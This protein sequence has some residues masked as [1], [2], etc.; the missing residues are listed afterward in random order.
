MELEFLNGIKNYFSTTFKQQI[1]VS[2]DEEGHSV[3]KALSAI[4]PAG[5]MA[6]IHHAEKDDGGA[7][8]YQLAQNATAYHPATQ[9][10]ALL[11]NEDGEKLTS[12]LL[13]DREKVI[14]HSVAK[15]AGI[16][17]ESA[18]AIMYVAIP[19]LLRS[20]DGYAREKNLSGE[21][22]KTF[23]NSQKP[24]LNNLI[25]QG[26]EPVVQDIE[27]E[28]AAF[29]KEVVEAVTTDSVKKNNTAWILPVA[30]AILAALM[31]IYFSRGT[32][33]LK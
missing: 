18:S 30:L 24:H 25:P 6:A 12:D 27:R 14:R 9:D 20:I 21:G 7:F 33:F 23:L 3:D 16:K 13:G 32:T 29:G 4:I 10:V 22:F 26:F 11:H 8:V 28:Q 2:V 17:N 1:A 19:S 15:Y 31:L 5:L